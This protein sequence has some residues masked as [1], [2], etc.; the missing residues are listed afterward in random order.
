MGAHGDLWA[1][2]AAWAYGALWAHVVHG[3]I[4][5]SLGPSGRPPAAGAGLPADCLLFLLLYGGGPDLIGPWQGHLAEF[6]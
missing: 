5:G 4:G 1:H 2:E 6:F 3:R